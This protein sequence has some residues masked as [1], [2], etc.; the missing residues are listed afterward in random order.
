MFSKKSTSDELLAA[1][2]SQLLTHTIEKKAEQINKFAEAL[3]KLNRVAEIFDDLGFR[4]ESEATTRLLEVIAKKKSKPKTKSKNKSKTKPK[5]KSKN[6]TDEK[7]TKNLEEYGWVFN[8]DLDDAHDEHCDCDLCMNSDIANVADEFDNEVEMPWRHS[9][10]PPS[11][12][13]MLPPASEEGDEMMDSIKPAPESNKWKEI[14]EYAE[15]LNKSERP[16]V[17]PGKN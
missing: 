13:E 4:T 2:E 17:R 9:T 14:E 7:M 16:T 5:S 11:H 6:L 1:M 3:D 12:H 15:W 8:M 10:Q